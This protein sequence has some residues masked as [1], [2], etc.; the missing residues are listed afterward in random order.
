[1]LED[2]TGKLTLV[3]GGARS[4]KSRFAEDLALRHRGPLIYLA[5]ARVG[6]A[7]M[8]RR[9]AE[10]RK[11][12][13]SRFHTVE[14]P[15]EPHR[16]F[17]GEELAGTTVLVDCLTLLLSNLLLEKLEGLP[18]EG[19]DHGDENGHL[20]EASLPVLAYV[21]ELLKAMASSPAH[22]IIVSNEVGCG[23]V[24]DN[25]LGRVFRDLAGRANQLVAAGAAEVWLLVSGIPLQVR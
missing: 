6:D 12:R 1:M 11:R 20:E 8:A 13:G 15:L 24:P 16:V 10:H 2:C 17:T 21:E 4:G 9:V 7:E 22:T 25:A 14:E 3:T 23:L 19:Q 18:G 5:T